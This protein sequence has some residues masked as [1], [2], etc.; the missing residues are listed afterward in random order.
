VATAQRVAD[1]FAPAGAAA[2]WTGWVTTTLP[3]YPAGWPL[4]LTVLTAAL[5]LV[6]PSAALP[7]ALLV[8]VFPLANV[9]IGLALVFAAIGVLWTAAS[10]RDPRG[11]TVA[12]AGPLL[13]PI[14]A[15]ALLPLVAQLARN[16]L[17][18]ALQTLSAVALAASV[19]VTEHRSLPFSGS[20][21]P[22]GGAAVAGVKDPFRVASV[23]AR[24]LGSHP[25]L[26]GEAGVL[27]LAAIALPLARGRGRWVAVLAGALLAT[28]GALVA[29]HAAIL[30][31][32]AAGVITAAALIALPRAA[33]AG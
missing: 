15:L 4:G 12:A 24:M 17:R 2:V 5:G 11:A 32:A 27:A 28:A 31:F 20:A 3:F 21:T 33:E 19:A 7:F 22:L 16:P 8:T 14:A 23:I 9:S 29:P 18:R 1:R 10:W 30:P 26:I 13:W 25:A 6:M